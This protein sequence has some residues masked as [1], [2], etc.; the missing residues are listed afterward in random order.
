[1][2]AQFF[3][4]LTTISNTVKIFYFLFLFSFLRALYLKYKDKKL[5]VEYWLITLQP[6]SVQILNRNAKM[7]GVDAWS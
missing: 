4:F 5:A 1:M 2:I 3:Q 6:Y 7:R